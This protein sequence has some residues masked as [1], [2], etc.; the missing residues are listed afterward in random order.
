M[1]GV[2]RRESRRGPRPW[3]VLSTSLI[4][5]SSLFIIAGAQVA[6]AV[7]SCGTAGA[8]GCHLSLRFED[9]AGSGIY[10]NTQ[11][12]YAGQNLTITNTDLASTIG[13][14]VL[15]VGLEVE[16]SLDHRDTTYNLQVSVAVYSASVSG[17]TLSGTKTMT[18]TNGFAPFSNLSLDKAG[19]FQLIGTAAVLSGTIAPAISD[20]FRIANCV[21]DAGQRCTTSF[22]GFGQ[23][24]MSTSVTNTG[25]GR[26]ASSNGIDGLPSCTTATFT[27]PF[28]HGPSEWRVDEVGATSPT[29]ISLEVRIFKAWRQ[30]VLDKGVSSYRVCGTANFQFLTWPGN[31]DPTQNSPLTFNQATGEYTGLLADCTK[32]IT[33]FCQTVKSNG[34]DVIETIPLPSG[35]LVTGDP[36]GH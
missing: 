28:F 19:Y 35:G 29:T 15:P 10:T 22:Q 20:S 36:R 30:R 8:S 14:S 11:P 16:N 18:A 12:H 4:V 27:D 21:A 13:G 6:D 3:L 31:S 5:L 23:T 32:T 7:A 34:G 24:L 1:G 2:I 33:F 26:I 17:W 25:N 9:P